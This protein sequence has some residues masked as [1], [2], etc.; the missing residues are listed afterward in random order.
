MAMSKLLLGA[1]KQELFFTFFRVLLAP[2][3]HADSNEADE[4]IETCQ[5]VK[6]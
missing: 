1:T 4:T 6:N 2:K 3:I 5:A